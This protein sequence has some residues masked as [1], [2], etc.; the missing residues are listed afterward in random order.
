MKRLEEMT[1]Q[2]VLALQIELWNMCK[3]DFVNEYGE[4]VYND[5]IEIVEGE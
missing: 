5:L 2:E 4:E 1:E 3:S